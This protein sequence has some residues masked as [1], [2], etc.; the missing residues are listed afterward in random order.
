MLGGLDSYSSSDQYQ[1]TCTKVD[2]CPSLLVSGV[3]SPTGIE[4]PL[5]GSLYD[6][7]SH[8]RVASSQAIPP[9]GVRRCYQNV[10]NG[11]KSAVGA[12]QCTLSGSD[13]YQAAM[14]VKF[15]L[16]GF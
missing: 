3:H 7:L 9:I 10:S 1:S 13:S 8:G 6:A 4:S 12:S 2:P 16:G 11:R 14:D 15:D 5:G